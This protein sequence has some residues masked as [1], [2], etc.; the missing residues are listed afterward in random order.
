MQEVVFQMKQC[1]TSPIFYMGNKKRL[2]KKGLIDLF[3][4][5]IETFYDL[6][7]GSCTVTM[8]AKAVYYEV[9]DV[10]EHIMDLV[11]WF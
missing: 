3:P 7:A 8:N 11:Q 5:K 2:I 6:F 10:N 9:N 4:K 1:I